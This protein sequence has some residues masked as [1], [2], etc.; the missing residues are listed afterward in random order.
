MELTKKL[1]TPVKFGLNTMKPM[2]SA[3]IVRIV[4]AKTKSL[5]LAPKIKNAMM[6]ML[7]NSAAGASSFASDFSGLTGADIGILTSD[8]GE[9]TGA[10]YMLNAGKGYTA[11]KFP[12]SEAQSLVD[13]YLVNEDKFDE[14]FSAKAGKGGAPSIAAIEDIL[15]KY[16][17]NGVLNKRF[18]QAVKT[19]QIINKNS[20]FDGVLMAAADLKLPG[21]M[22]LIDILRDKKL[23]TGYTSG[24][25]KLEH[26][27]KAIDA[28]GSFDACMK[29]F[30]PLFSAADFQLGNERKMREVFAGNAGS[31]YKKWGLL[32]FPITSE[33]MSWLNNPKNKAIDLLTFA[34]R[35]LSV[36]QI[37]LDHTPELNG[38]AKWKSGKLKYTIKD[39][40]TA[41]FY[42]RSPSSTPNPVGNR[43]GFTMKK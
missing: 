42:F 7:E 29:R 15:V 37:Y 34:A 27:T 17:V 39:F 26:L 14:P 6:H 4:T 40:S 30:K 31:R 38:Q 10:V 36:D 12:K 20:I 43:I 13:Y 8:F 28:V 9:V 24:I 22:A 35:G 19:I 5:K 23:N 2:D 41:D 3:A 25:P 33:M 1:L 18:T 16:S 21:Y 32:H 11:A